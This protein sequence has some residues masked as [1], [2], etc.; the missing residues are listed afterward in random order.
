MAGE[1]EV[2]LVMRVCVWFAFR[3][4]RG[5]GECYQAPQVIEDEPGPPPLCDQG[6]ET[7]NGPF[8]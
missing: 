5:L 1:E 6:P 2:A 4:V 8:A 3:R 7:E